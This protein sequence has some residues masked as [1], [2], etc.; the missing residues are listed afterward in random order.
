MV[1]TKTKGEVMFKANIKSNIKADIKPDKQSRPF[2]EYLSDSIK[3]YNQIV[4]GYRL[5]KAINPR[6]QEIITAYVNQSKQHKAVIENAIKNG[7]V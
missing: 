4:R 2:R 5:L 7:E 6:N 1:K 3:E